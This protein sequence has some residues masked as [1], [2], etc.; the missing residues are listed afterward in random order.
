M[1]HVSSNDLGADA[2]ASNRSLYIAASPWFVIIASIFYLGIA[3][4]LN[5]ANIPWWLTVTI[6]SVMLLDYIY[7]IRVHGLRS[8][9]DSVGILYQDCDKWQYQLQSGRNLK[10]SLVKERSYCS[11]L[12]IILYFKHIT[13]GRY[14]IIP[15][16]SLSTQK[17]RL[18]AFK[19]NC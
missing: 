3:L 6:I 5:L 16:D 12:L 4:A 18:L 17:F 1:R 13:G 2:S 10:G 8:H 14:I 19:L 11:Q 7:V 9:K 15:R